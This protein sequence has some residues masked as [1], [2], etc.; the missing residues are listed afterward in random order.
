MGSIE[1]QLFRPDYAIE[2]AGLVS[3]LHASMRTYRVVTLPVSLESLNISASVPV[4]QADVTK[5]LKE[6]FECGPK[7]ETRR[8]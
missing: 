5:I 1:K 3:S 4:R 6:A 8:D 2:K 7:T